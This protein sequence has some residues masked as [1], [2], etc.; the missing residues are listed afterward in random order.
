MFLFISGYF[1]IKLFYPIY[2]SNEIIIPYGIHPFDICSKSP[3]LWKYI[4]IAYI[5]TFIFANIVI[6]NYIYPV[7]FK[8]I[9]KRKIE[10]NENKIEN[11]KYNILINIVIVNCI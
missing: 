10:K 4:K 7:I 1:T 11:N 6:S 8:N 9:K 2:I 3:Q 5:I